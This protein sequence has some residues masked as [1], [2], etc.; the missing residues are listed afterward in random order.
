MIAFAYLYGVQVCVILF[1]CTG[2]HPDGTRGFVAIY[3]EWIR[4]HDGVT[5]NAYQGF[6]LGSRD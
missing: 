1:E 6:K 5:V 4:I 3:V 2:S